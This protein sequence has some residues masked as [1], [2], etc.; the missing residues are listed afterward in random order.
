MFVVYLL[1]GLSGLF[2]TQYYNRQQ[3]GGDY[4]SALFASGAST[5]FTLDLLVLTFAF[6][7]AQQQIQHPDLCLL[8][9]G[10]GRAAPSLRA[11]LK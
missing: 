6:L 4:V 9:C 3:K 11:V 5:S 8:K 10:T 7:A 1:L 2:A